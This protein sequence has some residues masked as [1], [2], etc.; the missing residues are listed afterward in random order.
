MV[1]ISVVLPARNEAA[2]LWPVIREVHRA[3]AGLAIE[4]IVV[5]DASTDDSGR[6]LDEIALSCDAVRW[7]RLAA[8][9]GQSVAMMSG[10]R[11]AV[12]S[13]VVTMDADGQ[14]DPADISA[15]VGYRG[16]RG[17]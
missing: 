1:K 15:P 10:V 2:N 4:V 16:A 11:A 3:T 8:H 17:L 14:N 12:G 13:W 6:I 9:R 7:I 5:D